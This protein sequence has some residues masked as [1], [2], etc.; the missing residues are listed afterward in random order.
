MPFCVA[1]GDLN[2]PA[3]QAAVVVAPRVAH[4]A[5]L[6]GHLALAVQP[7]I[8]VSARFMR[9]VRAALPLETA[10]T[11]GRIVAVLA[12]KALV[13]RPG[14]N[15]RAVHAEVPAREPAVLVGALHRM[16]ETTQSLRH[17][18]ASARGFS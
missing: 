5:Q 18:Q 15:Q 10:A 14:L 8:H 12:H 4:E 11:A 16:T 9:L 17:A 1:A 2:W 6:P 7:G 3:N 13:A